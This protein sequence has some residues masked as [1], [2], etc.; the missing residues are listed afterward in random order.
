MRLDPERIVAMVRQ[1]RQVLGYHPMPILFNEDDHFAF[2]KPRNNLKAALG[3]YCS[4]GYFDPGKN[5][6]H[7]GY[8]SP[9][10]NWSLNTE[11]KR[12]FFN[13]IK[14]ITGQ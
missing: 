1:T 12:A 4:W 8:Q 2:D 14:E 9:P 5:D 7:D 6:Y 11:R 3:E 10:V 13:T